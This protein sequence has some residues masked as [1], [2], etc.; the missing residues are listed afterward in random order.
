M[1]TDK[2]NQYLSRSFPVWEYTKTRKIWMII[3]IEIFSISF[4]FIYK[5]FGELNIPED[6]KL[7]F[8][9][10]HM[11]INLTI[12]WF[13]L[14][15]LPKLFKGYFNEKNRTVFREVI[16]VLLLFFLLTICH[17]SFN[18]ADKVYLVIPHSLLDS[19][20]INLSIGV[21][22]IIVIL[23]L[24][25]IR[26]LKDNVYLINNSQTDTTDFI[27]ISSESGKE[28][29]KVPLKSIHYIKSSDNYSEVY[30][31]E[32]N[33]LKRKI[34]RTSLTNLENSVE[35]EFLFRIH[36]SYIIN[37]LNIESVIGNANKCAVQLKKIKNRIPVARSKRKEMLKRLKQ[38]PVAYQ[39]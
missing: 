23:L 10:G 17:A 28:L 33:E 25:K 9:L 3:F 32:E 8:Y 29:I 21:F 30:F 26:Q 13:Q 31:E 4:K 12:L 37:F 18:F 5:P 20:Y 16:W 2:L 24:A 36:R 15:A 7:F 34:F 11:L 35:S 1:I 39:I 38:L 6:K 19:L 22:P 27:E 14:F